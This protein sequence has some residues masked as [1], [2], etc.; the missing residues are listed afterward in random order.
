MSVVCIVYKWR[1]RR[2]VIGRGGMVCYLRG[3]RLK[4]ALDS[5]RPILLQAAARIWV[6][7]RQSLKCAMSK[8]GLRRAVVRKPR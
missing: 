3:K 7:E 6:S 8:L 1:E 5:D 2:A 4:T